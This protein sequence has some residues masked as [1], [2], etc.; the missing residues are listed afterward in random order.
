MTT[1]FF[2]SPHRIEKTLQAL[3]GHIPDRDIMLGRELTKLFETLYFGTPSQVLEKLKATS[4]KGEYTIVV[5]AH[6]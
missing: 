3:A 4:A 1:V 6:E 5:S 2:E